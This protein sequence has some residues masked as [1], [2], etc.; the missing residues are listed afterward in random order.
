MNAHS[1]LSR[2]EN[3]RFTSEQGAR[4][5]SPRSLQRAVVFLLFI[6][7]LFMGACAQAATPV[8]TFVKG[9][10]LAYYDFS[11]PGTFEEGAYDSGKVRLEIREGA[12]HMDLTQGDS[13]LWYG[14]WGESYRDVVIDVDVTQITD[15]QNTTYGVMCRARGTVGQVPTKPDAD[16]SALANESSSPLIANAA[17]A[18][19]GTLVPKEEATLEPLL[20]NPAE[21]TSEG[22]AEATA[23]S[24]AEATS[25]AT[26]EATAEATS[27][28]TTEATAEATSEATAEATTEAT[29]ALDATNINNGDGYLFLIEGTGRFSIQ[30]SKGR[31]VQ[32]LVDW[33]FSSDIKMGAASNSI[34]AVCDGNYLALYV[35][36]KFMADTSD[37]TYTKGQ[38]GLVAAAANR[39][40][41]QVAFDNLRVSEAKSG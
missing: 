22:T 41:N 5:R 19:E 25:E 8:Q 38:V 11:Q 12:Y 21:A 18:L 20:E 32:P 13:V 35:N 29:P 30:L 15:S 4:A 27:E 2:D 7:A 33:T 16:L 40:G 17:Q 1:P 6:A 36:G 23:E 34:R 14:Q 10:E 31:S 28:A 3:D 39:L 37:D 24:T 9:D 26:T